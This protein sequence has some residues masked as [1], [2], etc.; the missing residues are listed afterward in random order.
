MDKAEIVRR[1]LGTALELFL[2][3]QDPVSVHTLACA[4]CEIAESL[5]RKAGAQPFADHALATFQDLNIERLHAIQRTYSNAFKHMTKRNGK[6]RSDDGLLRD[7]NDKQNDAALF[8]GWYDYV[9]VIGAEPLEAQAFQAWYF[10]LHPEALSS[11]ESKARYS[12]IFPNIAQCARAEQKAML[13]K[14]IEDYRHDK[15]VMLH[16]KTDP[17][18]LMLQVF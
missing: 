2:N 10:A 11:E 8:V 3:N 13:R 1:Q 15:E 18:P 14:L 17:R 5:V 16:P 12:D 9:K 4:A 7:F 6:E